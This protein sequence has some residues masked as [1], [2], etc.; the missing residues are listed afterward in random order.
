MEMIRCYVE[1]GAVERNGLMVVN[2]PERVGPKD[3]W[4]NAREIVSMEILPVRSDK[5]MKDE[6]K[7][8]NI[9][10]EMD[11]GATLDTMAEPAQGGRVESYD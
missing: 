4:L 9:R 8:R 6:E 2:E 7:D 1:G 10:A 5:N 3:V 11:R